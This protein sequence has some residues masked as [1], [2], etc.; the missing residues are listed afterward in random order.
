MINRAEAQSTL[1]HY[2]EETSVCPLVALRHYMWNVCVLH[3][4]AEGCL[5]RISNVKLTPQKLVPMLGGRPER[6]A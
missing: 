3:Q 5:F 1:S 2:E 4:L 6:H